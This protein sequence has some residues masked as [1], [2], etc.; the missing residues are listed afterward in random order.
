MALT[1]LSV[2]EAV[3]SFS[4]YISRVLYRNERFIL[5]KGRRAVTELRPVPR[6]SRLGDLPGLLRALPHRPPAE[7]AAFGEEI[8]SARSSLADETSDDPW[9]F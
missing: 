7:A 5:R 3:R 2:T 9:A 8:E 1:E 6:G 4:E